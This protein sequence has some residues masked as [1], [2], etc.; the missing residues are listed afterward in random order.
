MGNCG[1]LPAREALRSTKEAAARAAFAAA[2]VVLSLQGRCG[3]QRPRPTVGMGTLE[4]VTIQDHVFMKNNKEFHFVG[5]NQY[6]MLDKARRPDERH[7]V[8][9]GFRRQAERA[10]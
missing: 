7:M 10:P 3:A 5:F 8:D 9:V 6:Y 4:R 2:L 1:T